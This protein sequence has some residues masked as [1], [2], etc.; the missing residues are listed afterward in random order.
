MTPKFHLKS[1]LWK[2]DGPASWYFITLTKEI[3]EEIKFLN[4]VKVGWGS[5]KVAA[6][7]GKT[8]WNTSVFPSKSGEYVLPVKAEVRKKEKLSPE[9][10]VELTI[11]PVNA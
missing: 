6:Q 9:D 11:S 2:Y 10:M 3:S 7:I 8:K 1:K 5:V 4:T